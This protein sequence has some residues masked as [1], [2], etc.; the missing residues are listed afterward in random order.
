MKKERCA[1]ERPGTKEKKEQ[2]LK[3]ICSYIDAHIRE[4]LN[5][6]VIAQT[7][8]VSVSTV[9]QLFQYR[10]DET[11]HQYLTKRRMEIAA[12]LIRRKIPLEKVGRKVGYADHSSFYR[13]FK[14]YYGTSPRTFRQ[15]MER[16]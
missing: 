12:E 7:F 9:T 15:N 14:A 5:L 6:A 10:S 4:P 8:H 16:K 1:N 13:A 11:F 3:N 2:M